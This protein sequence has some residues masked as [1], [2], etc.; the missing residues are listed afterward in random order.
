MSKKKKEPLPQ[1]FRTIHDLPF[2]FAPWEKNEEWFRFRIGTCHG[3]WRS[4]PLSYD[5]LVVDNEE[6]GNGHFEDTL[7]WFEN[8]C[9]RD[10]KMLRIIEILNKK[11]L[12]HLVDKRGFIA[13]GNCCIKKIK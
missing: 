4:T 13:D 9:R 2:E 5:I 1:P 11:F 8:S 10:R 6:P 3:L 7:Q 12:K